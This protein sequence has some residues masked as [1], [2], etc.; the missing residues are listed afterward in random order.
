[1]TGVQTCALPIY[2]SNGQNLYTEMLISEANGYAVQ[3]AIASP[4]KDQLAIALG[5]FS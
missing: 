1:M 4:D 2:F 3:V 5:C